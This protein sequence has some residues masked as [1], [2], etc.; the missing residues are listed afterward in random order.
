MERNEFRVDHL[1]GLSVISVSGNLDTHS[2]YRFD[3]IISQLLEKGVSNLIIEMKDGGFIG[4]AS[5][6]VLLRAFDACNRAGGSL[7]VCGA[8][9]TAR[10][11]LAALGVDQVIGV[12]EDRKGALLSRPPELRRRLGVV[13]RRR[14]PDRRATVGAPSTK[15]R[16][17]TDRRHSVGTGS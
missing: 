6:E 2:S 17:K 14:R 7:A 13:E 12:Y 5:V 16:R 9:R 15:E 1:E 11:T 3:E 8:S 10:E 4:T